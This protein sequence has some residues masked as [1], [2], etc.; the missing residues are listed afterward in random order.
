MLG[1][2][3]KKPRTTV[4]VGVEQKP[5]K[6]NLYKFV[7]DN[8][9]RLV[10]C[11]EDEGDGMLG[12]DFTVDN[13]RKFKYNKIDVVQDVTKSMIVVTWDEANDKRVD[14]LDYQEQGCRVFVD[15]NEEKYYIVRI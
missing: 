10:L 13:Y 6:Y 15:E 14:D 7:Y 8:K 4:I 1:L 2:T 11:L 9:K 12:W 5:E 3:K